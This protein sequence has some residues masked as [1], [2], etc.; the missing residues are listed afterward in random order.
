MTAT[1]IDGKL[2]AQQLRHSI[3]EKV[4]QRV[5]SFGVMTKYVTKYYIIARV[6]SLCMSLTWAGGSGVGL[7]WG[8]A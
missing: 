4:Q 2:I 5:S 8:L 6:A 3:K 1:L 7:Q